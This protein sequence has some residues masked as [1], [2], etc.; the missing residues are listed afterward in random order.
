[1]RFAA[2]PWVVRAYGLL[3]VVIVVVGAALPA[4]A[5]DETL[6]SEP[7]AFTDVADAFDGEDPIDIRVRIGFRSAF[8]SSTIERENVENAASD[9]RAATR[10][11]SVLD[12]SAVHNEL[13]LGLEV[14]VYH[15]LMLFMGLPLV[16][17]DDQEL[18]PY[19]G[20]SCG[21]G[22]TGGPCALLIESTTEDE[23]APLFLVPRTLAAKQRSGL[24]RVEL[25]AAWSPMN[26]YRGDDATWTL[27]TTFELPTGEVMQPCL[28]GAGCSAG[29]TDGTASLKLESR[30]SR[31]YRYFEPLL[32]ISHELSWLSAGE[33][34]FTASAGHGADALPTT[35]EVI[36]GSA[37]IP[38]EDRM[39][40]QRFSVELRT[41]A[42]YVSAGRGVGP[43]FDALGTSSSPHLSTTRDTT[44]GTPFTGVTTIGS[45]GALGIDAMV[46]MKAARYV[47][48]TVGADLGFLT[49]HL[50]T[51]A[52]DCEEGDPRSTRTSRATSCASTRVSPLYRPVID[53]PG[54]RFRLVDAVA[55]GLVARADGQ[56]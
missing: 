5:Q 56:F 46:V 31:R 41:R 11:R 4:R 38:W 6:L 47:R 45:H 53:A 30:W 39:R 22:S 54:Q 42:A 40:H 2:K 15:D 29:I 50:I 24:P 16:L 27:R 52:P 3:L 44:T 48:F 21:D 43:L 25:G 36:V 55:V 35:T 20:Q 51:G 10:Y 37:I 28:A 33:N 32:G 26:Q 7:I 9:G 14:G 8:S 34:L 49:D 17:S 13:R 12:A 23:A 19:N 18:H 1:M